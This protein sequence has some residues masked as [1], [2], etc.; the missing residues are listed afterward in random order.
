MK[1][2]LDSYLSLIEEFDYKENFP[3]IP[4][5]FT[6]ASAK[7]VSWICKKGHQWKSTINSRTKIRTL[8]NIS[9]I[10]TNC[11][12][13]SGRKLNK[14]NNLKFLM[15]NLTKEWHPTKNGD[16]GP[17]HFSKFSNKKVWWICINNHEWKTGINNRSNGTKCPYCKKIKTTIK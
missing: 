14:E 15:S 5:N 16:L 17:E 6:H 3:L 12:F 10:G 1:K 13:C 11:P 9:Y 4:E 2:Y 8:N 7:K